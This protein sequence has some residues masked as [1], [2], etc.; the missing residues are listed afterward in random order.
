MLVSCPYLFIPISIFWAQPR[1]CFRPAIFCSQSFICWL[2]V[3][4]FV[5]DFLQKTMKG[6][7]HF[8]VLC[9][10]E[11]WPW[12]PPNWNCDYFCLHE[13]RVVNI[14][15][16]TLPLACAYKCVLV[17]F[18]S[19]IIFWAITTRDFKT[20]VNFVHFC[21]ASLIFDS[22]FFKVHVGTC[23]YMSSRCAYWL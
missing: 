12:S 4:M 15:H 5:L 9:F 13:T 16:A 21:I 1:S 17:T 19:N 10:H 22:N 23:R 7:I 18:W 11:R 20:H 3:Y 14:G 2:Q 6:W 8:F